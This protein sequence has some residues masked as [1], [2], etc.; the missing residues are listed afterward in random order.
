MKKRGCRR[1][2]ISYMYL[3][4]ELKSLYTIF[5]SLQNINVIQ[6]LRTIFQSKFFPE[7]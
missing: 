3:K 2:S 7:Q 6:F 4:K 1:P 5:E